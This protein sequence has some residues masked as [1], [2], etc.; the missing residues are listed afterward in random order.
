MPSLAAMVM[1]KAHEKS[2][3]A[4]NK[5]EFELNFGFE[6]FSNMVNNIHHGK[7]PVEWVPELSIIFSDFKGFS[8]D[9]VTAITEMLD[10]TYTL[11]DE[12]N[13]PIPREN[14]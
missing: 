4:L 2:R 5:N 7:S 11:A 6:A 12:H 14:A 10:Y 9:E 13:L 1:N 3:E 8:E